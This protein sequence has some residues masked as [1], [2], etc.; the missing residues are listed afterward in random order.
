MKV[1]W[2]IIIF[3]PPFVKTESR[4]LYQSGKI[5]LGREKFSASFNNFVLVEHGC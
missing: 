4:D 5:G 1:S 2:F 3:P